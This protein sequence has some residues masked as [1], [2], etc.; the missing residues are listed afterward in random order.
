MWFFEKGLITPRLLRQRTGHAEQPHKI[1]FYGGLDDPVMHGARNLISCSADGNLRDISLLNEFQSLDFSQKNLKKGAIRNEEGNMQLGKIKDFA[2]SEFRQRDW[3]NVLT[4]HQAAAQPY[5]WSYENHSIAKIQVEQ[6]DAVKHQRVTS[7]A[8]SQCGNFGILGYQ[9]GHIQKFN[10]QSG[11][12]RGFFSSDNLE[13][14]E[15]SN[16][17][18]GLG[19]DSLNHFLVSCSLD[20]SIKL[21]D[22]YRMKVARSFDQEHSYDN[23]VYNRKN[24][25]I[26]VSTTNM[27]V[28]IHNVKNGLKKVRVFENVSDN[29]I[30][31]LCF[32]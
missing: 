32:S 9:N 8:V 15:H 20:G 7:V 16:S 18:T 28:V 3:Q 17:I 14:K 13:L 25:L 10:M 12:S 19:L 4:C 1:R 22:F 29:K 31:D 11:Q 21:W 26:A 27:D 30:T 6:P 24:D 5:L 23:L 2:F